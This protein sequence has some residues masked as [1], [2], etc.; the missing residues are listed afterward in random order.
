M[1]VNRYVSRLFS[2]KKVRLECR[3]YSMVNPS[4]DIIRNIAVLAHI[5]AGEWHFL[6]N[7]I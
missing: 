1:I 2:H 3:R 5:D 7:R 6:C 4:D